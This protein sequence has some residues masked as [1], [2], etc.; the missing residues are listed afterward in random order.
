MQDKERELVDKIIAGDGDAFR[1]LIAAHKRL[2][3]HIVV[4]MLPNTS[5]HEDICQDVFVKVYQ[6]LS[7]FNFGS[8]LSTWIATIANN[9]CINFLK[10][11]QVPLLEDCKN[12]DT[13]VENLLIDFTSPSRN[14]EKSDLKLQLQQCIAQLPVQYRNI[15]TLY[16]LEEM[17]YMEIGKITGLPD[18]TV[19]SYLFRARKLLKDNLLHKY[20]KEELW[21]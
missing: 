11:K 16:H 17:S 14:A 2:V 21:Q 5:D 6:N 10:K 1:E 19:K 20:E 13:P 15:L 9:T 3:Y 12:G 8:K 4:R 18:G 7:R